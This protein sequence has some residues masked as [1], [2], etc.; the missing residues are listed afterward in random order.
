MKKTILLSAALMIGSFA[1]AQKKQKSPIDGRIYAVT[2]TEQGKKKTEPIKDDISFMNGKFKSGHLMNMGFT[3]TDYD[4]EVDST[5]SPVT[6]KFTVEAKNDSQERFSW[7]GTITD[8]K[9]EGTAIMRKKGEIKHT[10]NF[11]GNWKNKKKPKPAPKPAA[12]PAPVDST[13]V[14]TDSVKTE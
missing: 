9:V 8:D 3:M 10:Y 11:S 5:A 12:P 1:F 4:Y 6:I 7:E 2:H 14:T 13:Q